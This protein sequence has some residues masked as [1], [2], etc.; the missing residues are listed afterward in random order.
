MLLLPV[1]R[2]RPSQSRRLSSSASSVLSIEHS[3]LLPRDRALVSLSFSLAAI[4]DEQQPLSHLQGHRTCRTPI[5]NQVRPS[6]TSLLGISVASTPTQA[7]LT[8]DPAPTSSRPQSLEIGSQTRLP[9][10]KGKIYRLQDRHRRESR[11]P[12]DQHRH[13]LGRR[14]SRDA[15]P[16]H[17]Q[18]EA[19]SD[20]FDS[21]VPCDRE[22]ACE[23]GAD[24]PG[25]AQE[26]RTREG[27]TRR[28]RDVPSC[29]PAWR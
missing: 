16:F 15:G 14:T 18:G 10:E 5:L 9:P 22:T 12:R 6:S 24:G 13:H 8:L 28:P 19:R 29:E 25:R 23:S 17:P 27:A 2:T 3:H 21:P 20:D 26:T 7:K 11:R 1:T 4:V